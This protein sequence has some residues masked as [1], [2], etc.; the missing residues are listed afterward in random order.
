[1]KPL[2]CPTCNKGEV[3]DVVRAGRR[4]HFRTIPDLELPVDV[5]IPTCT[6]PECGEEWLD[7]T[8]ATRVDEAM[9]V[10]YQA[11]LT[12]KA[13]DAIARLKKKSPQRDLERLL[14]LS[15]GYLSK[16]KHGKETTAPLVATL[17]LLANDPRRVDELRALWTMEPPQEAL[18]IKFIEHYKPEQ[19]KR[20]LS[21]VPATSSPPSV[22]RLRVANDNSE[23]VEPHSLSAWCA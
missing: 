20:H 23:A 4:M 7:R 15:A 17:M 19:S 8:I 14:G 16:L 3:K 13:E 5:A 9:K 18:S 21:R 2:I 12:S 22:V 1:M 6:N 10:A 11:A